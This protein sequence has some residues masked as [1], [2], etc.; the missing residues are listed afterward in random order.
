MCTAAP[1]HT[2]PPKEWTKKNKNQNKTREIKEKN[3]KMYSSE[4]LFKKTKIIDFF[5]F[6]R[7][8]I[9]YESRKN[10]TLFRLFARGCVH[11][12]VSFLSLTLFLLTNG[13]F[14]S[15]FVCNFVIIWFFCLI[16]FF[17]LL[18]F[19]FTTFV[20][21]L[22]VHY[23]LFPEDYSRRKR[24]MTREKIYNKV[25]FINKHWLLWWLQSAAMYFF[26]FIFIRYSDSVWMDHRMRFYIV[27]CVMMFVF[28]L[29][30]TGGAKL[31][32]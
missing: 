26:F 5:F 32:S 11:R 7:I 22:N 30:W 16:F 14:F 27:Y 10:K 19:R 29:N 21:L 12:T 9:K 23:T 8:I 25:F 6:H 2:P 1:T 17:S 15:T 13:F 24:R 31:K 20:P 3:K 28:C 4:N 18:S